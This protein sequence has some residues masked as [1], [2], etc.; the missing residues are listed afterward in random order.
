[1]TFVPR[2][3]EPRGCLA[4]QTLYRPID[5]LHAETKEENEE[6]SVFVFAAV[7]GQ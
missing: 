1:M 4:R 2:S 6:G 5:R 7:S 3:T